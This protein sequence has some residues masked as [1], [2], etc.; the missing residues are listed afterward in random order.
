MTWV[1]ER[2]YL[3]QDHDEWKVLSKHEDENVAR[4]ELWVMEEKHEQRSRYQRG[5]IFVFRVRSI[6]LGLIAD[7]PRS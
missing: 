4:K 6:G 7:R 2:R 3:D 1:V 5:E